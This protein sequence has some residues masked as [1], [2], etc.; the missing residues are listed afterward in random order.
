VSSGKPVLSA[1]QPLIVSIDDVALVVVSTR[2]LV[3]VLPALGRLASHTPQAKPA[4]PGEPGAE[5]SLTPK[6][7]HFITTPA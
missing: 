6:R 2:V 3:L 7:I 1:T 5:K 4:P